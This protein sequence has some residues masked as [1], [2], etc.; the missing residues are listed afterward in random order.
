VL[1]TDGT[2]LIEPREVVEGIRDLLNIFSQYT[3]TIVR[4]SFISFAV[5]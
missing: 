4:S 5:F 3:L 2:N 1:Q